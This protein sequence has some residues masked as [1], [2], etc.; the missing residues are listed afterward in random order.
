MANAEELNENDRK[1]EEVETHVILGLKASKGVRGT[2]ARNSVQI[3]KNESLKLI[4][5]QKKNINDSE[6][7][8]ST[9]SNI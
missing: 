9:V 2:Q 8:N 6:G 1:E 4:R 3:S 5:D 7:D